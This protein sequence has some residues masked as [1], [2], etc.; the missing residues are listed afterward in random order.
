MHVRLYRPV[1][2]QDIQTENQIDK[3]LFLFFYYENDVYCLTIN[4]S[5]Q[6]FMMIQTQI[7][8]Y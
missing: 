6:T 3:Q 2:Q 8:L 7:I 4:E 1:I 5:A